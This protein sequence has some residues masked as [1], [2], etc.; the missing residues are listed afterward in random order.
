MWAH[1]FSQDPSCQKAF[2][3]RGEPSPAPQPQRASCAHNERPRPPRAA[4]RLNL[5]GAQCQLWMASGDDESF[6]APKC[7]QGGRPESNRRPPGPQPLEK[8]RLTL[9]NAYRRQIRIPGASLQPRISVCVVTPGVTGISHANRFLPRRDTRV[10]NVL[11]PAAVGTRSYPGSP[12]PAED[13]AH[14]GVEE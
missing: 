1:L 11:K 5:R 2:S 3:H 6:S 7:T 10:D 4:C 8:R 14:S 9:T 13:Q 12:H